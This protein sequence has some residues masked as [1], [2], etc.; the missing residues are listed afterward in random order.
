MKKI[1]LILL[2]II[3]SSVNSYSF[4]QNPADS[5]DIYGCTDSLA[6]NFNPFATIDDNSCFY[7]NDTTVFIYGCMDPIALNYNPAANVDDG[8]CYYQNDTSNTEI[9]GCMDPIALNYNPNATID[10]GSCYYQNDST[11][12]DIYGCMD[13]VAINYNPWATIDDGSCFYIGDSTGTDVFGCTDT[14]ALN[15]NPLA[16]I[17]NGSCSYYCD[18]TLAYFYVS[19]IDESTGI[20]YVVSSSYS[21]D[22]IIDYL[23]D[24]GDGQTSTEEFPVHEYESEGFYMLCL[25]IVSETPNGNMFCTNTYC[26]TIGISQMMLKS[27]GM[28]LNIISESATGIE[29]QIQAI[30]DLNVYPN[31]A[32][33]NITLSYFLINNDLITTS[34]YDLSGRMISTFKT[35]LSAG[36]QEIPVDIS[37]LSDGLYQ[38]EIRT[39]NAKET[40]RFQ[41]IH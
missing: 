8:S 40:L 21:P 28:T 37:S 39:M 25:T 35:N 41:V 10:N 14:S 27:N 12:M 33:N 13:S 32:N 29:Q 1:Y 22:L 4:G 38:I 26:D 11:G 15:Y 36:Y 9:Y 19:S 31:P 30:N 20:I 6:L 24:F 16:T 18:S 2:L 5:T 23:W 34:I 3:A 17:D 7:Q